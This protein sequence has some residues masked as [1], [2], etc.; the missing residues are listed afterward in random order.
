MLTLYVAPPLLSKFV[1]TH[2]VSSSVSPAVDPVYEGFP[3][4]SRSA[5][6]VILASGGIITFRVDE[7]EDVVPVVPSVAAAALSD[8]STS[9]ATTIIR[10]F[11]LFCF[12]YVAPSPFL[13]GELFEQ[14]KTKL[15]IRG[16]SLLS[17]NH[18]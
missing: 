15:S 13:L 16:E 8:I 14:L 17:L 2:T 6:P 1:Y 4:K 7:P 12:I 9:D 11:T 18:K 10:L 5:S 3:P